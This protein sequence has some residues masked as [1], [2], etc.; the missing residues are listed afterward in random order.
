MRCGQ[1]H[2]LGP[3]PTS[4][5]KPGHAAS[6][7]KQQNGTSSSRERFVLSGAGT[8]SGVRARDGDQYPLKRSR[9]LAWR[10]IHGGFKDRGAPQ[11]EARVFSRNYLLSRYRAGFVGRQPQEMMMPSPVTRMVAPARTSFGRRSRRGR[12]GGRLRLCGRGCSGSRRRRSEMEFDLAA[13]RQ[14]SG[15]R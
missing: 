9:D 10:R 13:H 6:T 5:G 11:S 2:S 7:L 12:S 15:G 1:D 8:A 4:A 14:G 3:S